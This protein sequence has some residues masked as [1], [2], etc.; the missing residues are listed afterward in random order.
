MHQIYDY[1]IYVFDCDG[2]VFD[3]NELKL[4]AMRRA[5]FDFSDR[6]V[7]QCIG[8][9]SENFGKSRYHHVQYFLDHILQQGP[10]F[11]DS[12]YNHILNEYSKQCKNLYTLDRLS[13]GFINF[14]DTLKS[15]L[16]IAS[17]SD[18][19]ELRDVFKTL[20]IYSKFVE[21]YGSPETKSNNIRKIV[22]NSGSK[23]IVIIGDS[24]SDLESAEEN[25]I[26]FIFYSPFSKVKDIMKGVCSQKQYLIID[27][28][29]D[30]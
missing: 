22:N 19:S 27:S 16:Y 28:F 25:N 18:E 4:D 15:P 13:P 7:E 12:Q 26:D 8:Y 2:V 24:F 30:L 23:K 3:S 17:G 14:V 21:V 10:E 1:D 20:N 29:E 11:S 5:L 6:E 9:F